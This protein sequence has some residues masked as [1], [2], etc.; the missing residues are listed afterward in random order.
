MTDNINDYGEDQEPKIPLSSAL[1]RA[2][3]SWSSPGY[4]QLPFSSVDRLQRLPVTDETRR[5]AILITAAIFAARALSD[6]DG[7]RSPGAVAAVA[8]GL[9]KAKF[10]VRML[11]ANC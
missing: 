7:K 11:E 8:Q 1:F 6:W 9:E 10:L 5:S 4:N 3:P 2:L